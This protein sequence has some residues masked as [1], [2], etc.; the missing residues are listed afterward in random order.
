MKNKNNYSRRKKYS[1]RRLKESSVPQEFK[2]KISSKLK[3]MSKYAFIEEEWAQIR[4]ASV[5]AS[6]KWL[7]EL[8]TTNKN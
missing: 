1:I 4:K 3:Q 8:K 6:G 7:M 2:K 5:N